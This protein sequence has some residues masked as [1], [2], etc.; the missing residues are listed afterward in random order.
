MLS[1]LHGIARLS[2]KTPDKWLYLGSDEVGR[3]LEIVAI[4][5]DDGVEVVI[6]AMKMRK[7][8]L[9]RGGKR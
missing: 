5:G 3:P 6:H 8:Y 9:R 4:Q 1:R 7:R 2:V